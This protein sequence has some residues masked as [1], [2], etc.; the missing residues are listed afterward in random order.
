[1][2]LLL[3]RSRPFLQ[4]SVCSLCRMIELCDTL[5]LFFTSESTIWIFPATFPARRRSY[6]FGVTDWDSL[7]PPPHLDQIR[8]LLIHRVMGSALLTLADFHRNFVH[9]SSRFPRGTYGS[10]FFAQKQ[11]TAARLEARTFHIG[12]VPL[13][14]Y[15]TRMRSYMNTRRQ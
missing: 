5:F 4:R 12:A 6:I 9:A 2:K 14:F 7:P 10:F 3:L 11:R 15:Y 13:N 1:M 8:A